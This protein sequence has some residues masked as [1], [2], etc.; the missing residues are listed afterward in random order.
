MNATT[1]VTEAEARLIE[2]QKE[3]KAKVDAYFK[4]KNE[5]SDQE[6]ILKE[7][8]KDIIEFMEKTDTPRLEGDTCKISLVIKATPSMPKDVVSKQKLFDWIAKNKGPEVLNDML[9][10]NSRSFG[11][12]YNAE[13][14]AAIEDGNLDFAID[15]VEEPH[16]VTSIAVR[17][18]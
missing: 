16:N 10:F 5:I 15:G 3:I 18:K 12:F 8:K 11:S 4:L 17:K 13:E 9:T 6:K 7:A 14:K 2:A 1:Q